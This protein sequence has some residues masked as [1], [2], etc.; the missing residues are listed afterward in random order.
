MADITIARIELKNLLLQYPLVGGQNWIT[1]GPERKIK[2]GEQLYKKKVQTGGQDLFFPSLQ[3][4]KRVTPS[5][6]AFP[7]CDG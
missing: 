5:P 6:S 3:R 2:E 1:A 4:A 7:G